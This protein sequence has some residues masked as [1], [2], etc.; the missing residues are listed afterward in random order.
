MIAAEHLECLIARD[1]IA[2][3]VT[4]LAAGI[5]R[6]YAG[7]GPMTMMVVLNG[8]MV[9]VFFMVHAPCAKSA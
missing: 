4:E 7:R 9:R 1:A 6:D 3:R 5:E 2:R 8:A